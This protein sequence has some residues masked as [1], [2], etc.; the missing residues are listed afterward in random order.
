MLLSR[1]V[2]F[3]ILA[4]LCTAV[5]YQS[6]NYQK[7]SLA[8][9]CVTF[10]HYVLALVYSRH[11]IKDI[12]TIKANYLPFALLA[13]VGGTL[14]AFGVSAYYLFALHHALNESYIRARFQSISLPEK[15]LNFLQPAGFFVHLSAYM[16][17]GTSGI[18][19]GDLTAFWFYASALIIS[20]LLYFSL[21]FKNRRHFNAKQLT[22]VLF[23]ELA[24][25]VLLAIDLTVYDIN[26][27]QIICYHVLFWV[28][29]PA[30]NLWSQ[31]SHKGIVTYV[32]LTIIS[33]GFFVYLSPFATNAWSSDF[34][35]Y[36][37]Q[38]EI[39]SYFH[40][41]TSFALSKANPAWINN[42]FKDRSSLAA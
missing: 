18:L 37:Q 8:L 31:K 28:F 38:F 17:I 9:Y 39:W 20:T 16:I 25:F 14:F 42:R 12:V 3:Q 30:G 23:A 35:I 22:S 6:L 34:I 10:S 5:L 4:L 29:F 27:F 1:F 24:M 11:Y 7:A 19:R 15:S 36:R 26:F 40:I 33:V 2:V 32:L 13:I 21:V 41:I